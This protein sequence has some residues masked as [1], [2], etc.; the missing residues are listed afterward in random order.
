M[1]LVTAAIKNV[2]REKPQGAVTSEHQ[3]TAEGNRQGI[4]LILQY[5]WFI[6]PGDC[7]Y[8]LVFGEQA[9]TMGNVKVFFTEEH[10]WLL[11]L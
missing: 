7:L 2:K 9:T 11:Y 8:C 6:F 5:V 10:I 3:E 4:P 1:C